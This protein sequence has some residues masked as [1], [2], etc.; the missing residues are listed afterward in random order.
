MTIVDLS[1]PIG[2]DPSGPPSVNEPIEKGVPQGV[3][4]LDG[5]R[6]TMLLHPGSDVDFTKHYL[7]DG[8]TAETVLLERTFRHPKLD[9]KQP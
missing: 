5:L 3:R 2:K 1:A 7:A 8:R 4:V 9:A 6:I